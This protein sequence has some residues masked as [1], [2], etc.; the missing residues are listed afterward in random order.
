[1]SSYSQASVSESHPDVGLFFEDYSLCSTITR[2][3]QYLSR[4]ASGTE[5]LLIWPGRG[6]HLARAI[7]GL[8]DL[9]VVWVP[10]IEEVSASESA[11]FDTVIVVGDDQ[12]RD[13]ARQFAV[14]EA[15]KFSREQVAVLTRPDGPEIEAAESAV[16]AFERSLLPPI[17]PLAKTA[18]SDPRPPDMSEVRDVLSQQLG[19]GVG[20]VPVCHLYSWLGMSLALAWIRSMGDQPEL[21]G[22][23]NR[24]YN[25]NASGFDNLW[26]ARR[27]LLVAGR[28]PEQLP[29]LQDYLSVGP[30]GPGTAALRLQLAKVLLQTLDS[31]VL[32]TRDNYVSRVEEHARR[33][34]ARVK[35][36][37]ASAAELQNEVNALHSNAAVAL[38]RSMRIVKSATR[39]ATE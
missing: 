38:L 6:E 28:H 27:A 39:R 8:K 24:L 35:E 37:E 20:E 1:M 17:L 2:Y 36:L 18:S 25:V 7:G 15:A 13:P 12:P 21:E 23:I 3:L 31:L 10:A 19:G 11:T 29:A 4:H 22:A 5:A 32:R 33:L 26:P 16:R 9:R 34:E 30:I 14:P